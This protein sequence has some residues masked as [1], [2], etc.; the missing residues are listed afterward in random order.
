MNARHSFTL[1]LIRLNALYFF[2]SFK[3]GKKKSEVTEMK[4]VHRIWKV[5][6]ILW[7]LLQ[8]VPS[9]KIHLDMVLGILLWMSLLEQALN[10]MGPVY[11]RHSLILWLFQDPRIQKWVWE[12]HATIK[13]V[14]SLYT[15]DPVYW[16]W[17]PCSRSDRNSDLCGNRIYLCC[18][19]LQKCWRWGW[20]VCIRARY[21][22]LW[23]LCGWLQ[24]LRQRK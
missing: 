11:F 19:F 20:A 17:L 21:V 15:A 2:F 4:R 1:W 6:A 3:K 8:L 12:E 24:T 22:A 23:C 13:Q 7:Y 9:Y 14:Y 16:L 18:L 10:Q 5:Q